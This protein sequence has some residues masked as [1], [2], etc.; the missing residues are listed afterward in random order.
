MQY[1]ASNGSP[2]T[3]ATVTELTADEFL[4][5]VLLLLLY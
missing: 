3:T 5:P 1:T 4:W 2:E